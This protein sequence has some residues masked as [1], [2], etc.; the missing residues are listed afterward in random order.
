MD[1]LFIDSNIYLRFYDSNQ[2][3]YKKLIYAL[4]EIK[5]RIFITKQ[6]VYEVYRNKAKVF[7]NSIDSYIELTKINDITLPVQLNSNPDN[8]IKTWNEN[9]KIILSNF[10][11]HNASLKE[12]LHETFT[13]VIH[14]QDSVSLSLEK[15]FNKAIDFNDSEYN[16]AKTRKERGNPPGKIDDP[17]GD[18]INW[19]QLLN[20]INKVN[21]IWIIS[22]DLDFFVENNK[23]IF[24]NPL[25]FKELTSLNSKIKI[26]CFK[27]LS[28]GLRHFN[29]NSSITTLPKE[30]ELNEILQKERDSIYFFSGNT[31]RL[32]KVA[33]QFNI[34]ISTIIEFLEEKG[35]IIDTNPNTKITE[36]QLKL[37]SENFKVY[38]FNN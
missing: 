8:I 21:A 10:K 12:I 36:D 15:V 25:L 11:N 17:L 24:L 26:H 18:Q 1:I 37:I 29:K 22:N 9:Q 31:F 5:D 35:H 34:G 19:E 7:R 32:S 13:K 30:E 38:R 23:E 28:E 4:V 20:N 33:R 3:E 27:T 16:K 14:S 6:I 2:E